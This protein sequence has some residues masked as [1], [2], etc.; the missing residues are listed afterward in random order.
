[1]TSECSCP[2]C[3]RACYKKPG[4]FLPGEA[5]A[6]ASLLG[7]TLGAFFAKHLGVDYWEAEE[8]DEERVYV[9]AP[10]TIIGDPGELYPTRPL[11]KCKL[12]DDDNRCTIYDARPH[13]CREHTHT[14]SMDDVHNRHRAVSDAWRDNQGQ[15]LRLLGEDF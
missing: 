15:I 14:E 13:E 12:L 2:G 5:E 4:W 9:L 8:E 6:A 10:V 3:V 1:M 7:M 11:G